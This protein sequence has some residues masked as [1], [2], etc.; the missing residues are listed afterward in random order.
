MSK[1]I[2]K[3]PKMYGEGEAAKEIGVEGEIIINPPLLKQRLKYIK[4]CNFKTND[5][6]EV[7][8]GTDTYD[9]IIKMI[10]IAEAHV[11]A[12]DVKVVESGRTYKT[13]LEMQADQACDEAVQYIASLI[14]QGIKAGKI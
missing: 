8:V 6:G 4:E 11:E 3:L 10:D 5:K 9:A 1:V 13:F 7:E 2:H 14:L 12:V